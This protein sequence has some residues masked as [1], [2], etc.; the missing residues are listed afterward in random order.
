MNWSNYIYLGLAVFLVI[1]VVRFLKYP[2]YQKEMGSLAQELGFS[3]HPIGTSVMPPE[4]L[5]FPYFDT[6][7][8]LNIRNL[9]QGKLDNTTV[10]L[11]L[12]WGSGDGEG[13]PGRPRRFVVCLF[14]EN[15]NV[16]EVELCSEGRIVR[17]ISQLGESKVD[18]P[19]HPQ[20]SKHYWVRGEDIVA[21]RSLLS[22]TALSFLAMHPGWHIEG[23]AHG[24]L[25]YTDKYYW[26][27]RADVEFIRTSWQEITPLCR[28][29]Q[30]TV[31]SC[32]TLR[33]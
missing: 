24:M 3:V 6:V 9:F 33:S 11:F 20:F 16:P 32:P 21:I 14:N 17:A 19:D 1:T 26:L 25:M 27:T 12:D 18:F 5:K 23:K 31:E 13:Y 2:A 22:P 28:S 30:Q 10:L 15:W 7:M 4:V 8:V 29:F